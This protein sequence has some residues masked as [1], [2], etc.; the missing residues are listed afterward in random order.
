[1]AG[2]GRVSAVGA[3]RCGVGGSRR[4]TPWALAAVLVLALGACGVKNDPIP[5]SQVEVEEPSS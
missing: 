3:A 5:P 1:M 2:A 4:R